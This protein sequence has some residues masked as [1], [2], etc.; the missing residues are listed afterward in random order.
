M[1]LGIIVRSDDTGLGNQT[2]NLARLLKPDKVMVIDMSMHNGMEQHFDWYKDYEHIIIRNYPTRSD[3]KNFLV[4][5]THLLTCEIFYNNDIVNIARLKGVKTINQFNYEFLDNLVSDN[6]AKPDIFL[7]PS[8]WKLEETKTKFNAQYLPPPLFKDDFKEARAN[9]FRRKSGKAKFLHVV[10]KPAINS[11]NGTDTLYKA[12]KHSTELYDLVIKS[13]FKI[14]VE[15]DPRITYEIGNK[16]TSADLYAGYD[17]LI[18]PRKFGGLALPM[19]EALM[20]GLPV[21]MTDIEPNNKV[22]PKEWLVP[23]IRVGQFMTRTMINLHEA[24]EVL[25]GKKLDK[26]A[27]KL[28]DKQKAYE[29]GMQFFG[30]SVLIN[31]YKSLLK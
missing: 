26:L 6:I 29:L 22:L 8:Y 14:P 30:D 3:S 2:R 25:L 7:S 23:A 24:N 27:G 9:N 19:N 18:Y 31:D 1:R 21:I 17:A 13:Q 15:N 5:L 11:R 16:E 10:G 28:P 4:G 12:L 20:S